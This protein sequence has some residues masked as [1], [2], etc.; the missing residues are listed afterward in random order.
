[1]CSRHSPAR[2]SGVAT[3]RCIWRRRLLYL[4]AIDWSA[5]LYLD[6][7]LE[8]WSNMDHILFDVDGVLIHS[9]T[10]SKEYAQRTGIDPNHMKHFFTGV[11]QDCVIGKADLKEVITPF[12]KE[13]KWE[14]SPEAFLQAW[15][16]FENK[17][18]TKLLS[19][20]QEIRGWGI[21][22]QLATN[23]EKYRLGYLRD[24]MNFW[25]LFDSIFSSTE[26]W[27]KKP[28]EAF[29]TYIIDSLE[30]DAS[31]ILYFDDSEENIESARKLGIQWVIYRNISD[32]EKYL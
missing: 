29:Y 12:L 10:W 4:Q 8:W 28:H 31:D 9:E 30:T 22:C 3:R 15:F 17:P 13:W 11:F 26:I 19:L 32:L 2:S 18:D 20:I 27:Y 25:N 23:N 16:D 24:E 7:Y 14:K 6:G 5:S 21:K 1:M